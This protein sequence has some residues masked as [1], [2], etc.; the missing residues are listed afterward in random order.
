[1]KKRKIV[2]PIVT[3]LFVGAGIGVLFVEND[4]AKTRYQSAEKLCG[5]LILEDSTY[6]LYE[7]DLQTIKKKTGNIFCLDVS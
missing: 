4:K 5:N 2:I 3:V 7:K 6:D 1:M